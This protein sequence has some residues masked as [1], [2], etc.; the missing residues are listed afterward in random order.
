MSNNPKIFV[1][2]TNVLLH[3]HKALSNFQENDIV[4]PIIVLEELDKFKKGNDQINFN[5]RE[6]A[7]ELDKI[8]GDKMLNGWISMGP[9]RGR[10]KVELGHPFP[11]VMQDSF[12][13]D[14]PDHRILVVA[15]HM[16]ENNPGRRVI[17][18]TKDVNLRIKSKALGIEAQD[19]L[20]DKVHE[21][22]IASLSKGVIQLNRVM[23]QT[24]AKLYQTPEGLSSK[25]IR[26]KK[27]HSNQYY[28]LRN[29]DGL[30]L[31]RYDSGKKRL[32][33]VPNHKAYG[34][35]PRNV[36]QN[37]ALDAL[38]NPS[39]SLVSLT[40]IAGTGKTLLALAAA[41]A[42]EDDYDQIM[43]SR[44]VI[45]LKN[46]EMGFLPGDIKEKLAPYMLPLMD[47]LNVIK[48]NLKPNSREYIR[49]EEMLKNEKLLISPLAYIRGRSLSKVFFIVDES[50]NLTPHEVKTIITRA[51][52]GSKLV[53]T[54]DIYQIDQ[55]YLDMHSNGLTYLTDKMLGQNLFAHVNLV[56]GERSRL[57]ELAG[58]IL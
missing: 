36:E 30:A 17:L 39:V 53:F 28:I 32:L 25:D 3:D 15:Q 29:K 56:K 26:L 20:T 37:F 11:D 22:S 4:I 48:G 33:P 14:T 43:L 23:S 51:G 58:N 44:P 19:Y 13:E 18:I 50:Q 40:G 54:G 9:D 52:E 7:R 55:P 6:F 46:Q 31:A 1:L 57:A 34:I 45:P 21:E 42:Q 8:L 49:I 16:K 41:L 12:Y 5:A 47:N 38:L 10:L 27:P 35:S 2:D 24:M